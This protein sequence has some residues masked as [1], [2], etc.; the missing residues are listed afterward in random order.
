MGRRGVIAE[1]VLD[2]M[3]AG[4]RHCW[5]LDDLKDALVRRGLEPDPSSVFRAVVRLEDAGQVVR[6]P[7]D[8]R[9]GHYEVAGEH[10]EHLIC[11]ACGGIEPIDCSVV[12]SLVEKVRATSG[13]A[14]TGHQVVLSGTCERC[15]DASPRA[16]AAGAR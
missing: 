12:A 16:S 2:L 4:G 9:R 8:D 11:E 10:H 5:S 14:V 6:V 1:Q 3:R 7:I 13:F 15:L